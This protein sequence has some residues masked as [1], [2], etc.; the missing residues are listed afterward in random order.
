[1]KIEELQSR[2]TYLFVKFSGEFQLAEALSCFKFV[3]QECARL[4][5]PLALLDVRNI[6]G[7]I[8]I[9]A[10]HSMGE[11]LAE[12]REQI[13]RLAML[14]RPD[15]VLPDRFMQT[16]ARNRGFFGNAFFELAEAEAWLLGGEKS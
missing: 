11:G 4:N 7:E 5:C 10:R 1:M 2:D 14:A 6:T 12:F 15:Q 16:V 13:R 9:L 3:A 8:N